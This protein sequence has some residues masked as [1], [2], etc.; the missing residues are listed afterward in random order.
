[1]VTH[2][3]VIVSDKTPEKRHM[4]LLFPWIK[5]RLRFQALLASDLPGI[6]KHAK[7]RP[8]TKPCFKATVWN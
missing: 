2:Q 3:R 6:H 4:C 5:V 1:M 8:N 7:Y